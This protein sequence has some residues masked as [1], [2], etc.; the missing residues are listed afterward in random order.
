MRKR[1]ICALLQLSLISCMTEVFAETI[2]VRLRIHQKES[3]EKTI[4]REN[5][6]KIKQFILEQGNR[7]TYCNMYNNNPA[8]QTKNFRFYLNPDSGQENINCDPKKSGF[9]NLTIRNSDGGKNQYRAVEFLDK[10]Y[11]YITANW[12]TD[13]LTVQQVRQFV[14]DAMKEILAEIKKKEPNKPDAGDGK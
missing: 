1:I 10:H 8:Y 14:V 4:T 2:D 11:V 13:D 9:H 7:E 12:P 5:L 6:I 3:A